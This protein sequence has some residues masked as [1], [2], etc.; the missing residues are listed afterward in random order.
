MDVIGKQLP[1][2]LVGDDTEQTSQRLWWCR[3]GPPSSLN[4]QWD[5]YTTSSMLGDSTFFLRWTKQTAISTLTTQHLP[6]V[7][8][9]SIDKLKLAQITLYLYNPPI[10]KRQTDIMK[11]T[12]HQNCLPRHR[13][14]TFAYFA[15]LAFS[16][17]LPITLPLVSAG[18]FDHF[19]ACSF[20]ARS[21][22]TLV[23]L[24]MMSFT[25][26]SFSS[27]CCCFSSAPLPLPSM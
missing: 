8:Q 19:L 20:L 1:A 13:L 12:G 10:K 22:F 25:P 27:P 15:A 6:S 18:I 7:S 3:G 5:L 24:F 9:Q 17:H 2:A 4:K 11:L 23:M 16:S 26:L 21:F 14:L